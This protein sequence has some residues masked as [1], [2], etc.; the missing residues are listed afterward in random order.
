MHFKA[1]LSTF[2]AKETF[3]KGAPRELEAAVFIQNN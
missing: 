2:Y 1:K 3:E